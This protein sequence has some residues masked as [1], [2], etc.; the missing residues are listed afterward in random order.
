MKRKKVLITG[1]ASGIGRASAIRFSNEGYD[2][3]LNDLHYEKLLSVMA[4]L[5]KGNHL[6]VLGNYSEKN[7]MIEGERI[8][9]E[10]WGELDVLIN[11]AGIFE[12]TDAIEMDIQQWRVVFDIMLNGCLL[13]SQLAAKLMK[14]SGRIVH[15]TSIHATRAEKYASS[16]STAKAAM[17]QYCRSL[18]LELA[19]KNILVNAIA[20]GFVKT[21]MSIIDGENELE[22]Q[23][24]KDNYVNSYR[25]P[26]R[27]AAEA[28]EVA[29]VALFLAGND[30]T[31]ITGQVII[32]DGGLSITF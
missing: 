24:F 10:N 31:Y 28:Y 30:S 20:P 18:A 14:N 8:I 27:R 32:V 16:Y 26:L 21:E 22:S 19:D 5:S 15:I 11:C 13:V 9:K 1:A 29:G 25:L 4:E 3:C 6:V 12:K 23:W 2:V 7:T 17:N